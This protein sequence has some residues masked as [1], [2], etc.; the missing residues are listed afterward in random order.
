MLRAVV[1]TA[2]FLCLPTLAWGIDEVRFLS[3][4]KM[5]GTVKEIRKEKR[6]FD[7]EVRIGGRTMLRTYAYSQVHSVT[8]NGRTFVLT[9][10]D[11]SG[12]SNDG[13][14]GT[15][16]SES[17]VVRLIDEAG[18]TP[19]DW[20]E[21]IPLEYPQSL[22]LAW[23]L[24]PP[25]K[26]WQNQVNV[27]Q[28]LWDIIYPN[29]KRWRPGIRLV[30]HLMSLHQN[31]RTLLQRDMKTLGGMYFR[32]LQDYPRAAYWLRQARLSDSEP[33]RIMLAECYWRLGSEPMANKILSSRS[34]PLQAIKLYGDMGRTDQALKWAK[35][36]GAK[37]PHEAF[38]LAGDACRQA[39]RNREAIRYYEK[40]IDSP[41]ARNKEYGHRFRGRAADSIEAIRLSE[42]ADVSNVADG[43]YRAA[44]VGYNGD[45]DVEVKVAGGRIEDV[46]VTRHREKQ[47][48]AAITDTL[49]QIMTKQSVR[50]IDATSRAT[51]T[52]QAIVNATAKALASGARSGGSDSARARALG[53]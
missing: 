23:P 42:Q 9:Q 43:T 26:G 38:L 7:F 45:I 35:L 37:R 20:F 49:Q 36:H 40:V 3:G 22:D 51:I 48:Y 4:A 41:E 8:I 32:L 21:S 18:R 34:L 31:D 46:R 10:P 15:K 1:M 25:G 12:A 53:N 5:Q 29:P 11:N 14:N 33:L 13:T 52:S 39:G 27:G 28:Y 47:F 6:E 30:H 24:K 19:P 50:K 44:S 17:E 16:R 2:V